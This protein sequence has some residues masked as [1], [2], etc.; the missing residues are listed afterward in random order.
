MTPSPTAPEVY[1]IYDISSSHIVDPEEYIQIYFIEEKLSFHYM[2][3]FSSDS[4]TLNFVQ[5]LPVIA[6]ENKK[7]FDFSISNVIVGV[8]K[9]SFFLSSSKINKYYFIILTIILLFSLGG[10]F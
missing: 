3:T 2:Q 9:S 6:S 5:S 1:E 4:S 8:K 10:P 7:E